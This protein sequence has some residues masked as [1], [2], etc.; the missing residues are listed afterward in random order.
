MACLDWR[1]P[2]TESTGRERHIVNIS[3]LCVFIAFL[4]IYLPKIPLSFAMAKSR[5]GYDNRHPRDQQAALEGWGR[6]A[7]AAHANG[8][9]SFAP[10]AAAVLVAHVTKAEVQLTA[11]LALVHVAARTVYPLVY[12]A[13]I[14][15][16]RSTVWVVGFAATVGLFVVGIQ[17]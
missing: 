11:T 10:F 9:E 7:A 16:L 2:P 5:G 6:R 4:L 13:G 12:I 17:V 14:H 3:L 15:V 8:F 1:L